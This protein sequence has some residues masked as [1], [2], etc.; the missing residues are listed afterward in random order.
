M[1]TGGKMKRKYLETMLDNEME[2]ELRF[3]MREFY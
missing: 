3:V 1:R 2:K